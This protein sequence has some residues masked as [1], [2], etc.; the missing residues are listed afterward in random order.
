M[1]GQDGAGENIVSAAANRTAE[2]QSA[3]RASETGGAK[4]LV[5][6]VF[7]GDANYSQYLP[8]AVQSIIEHA[9]K[10][11]HYHIIIFDCGIEADAAQALADQCAAQDNFSCEIKDIAYLLEKYRQRFPER[12]HYTRAMYGRL[13][14]PELCGAYD[15]IIYSDIDVVFERD[16]AELMEIDLSGA[17][18]GAVT[19]LSIEFERAADK[20][21]ARYASE[22]LGLAPD[23]AC[24]YSGL[25]VFNAPLWRA[26]GVTERI[27]RFLAGKRLRC[28][29]QDA[30]TAVC[31]GKITYLAQAWTC[32]ILKDR[33]ERFARHVPPGR[34]PKLDALLA[35]WKAA[36]ISAKTVIHYNGA[37]KPWHTPHVFL[38][39]KWW[40]YARRTAFY[41][42]YNHLLLRD[43]TRQDFPTKIYRFLGVP[44]WVVKTTPFEKKY[45][46]GKYRLAKKIYND[47]GSALYILGIK[48]FSAGAG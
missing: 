16:I 44:V 45:L 27:I 40:H 31:R 7:C 15:R 21:M 25:L 11:C 28:P 4:K 14:I 24:I 46:L 39:E 36:C 9:A 48:L 2:Q 30:I 8:V 43:M 37:V 42:Y 1:A 29:D 22:I 33:I 20:K 26:D 32:V 41:P 6:I 18:I 12:L 13:F 17:Y 5:P 19:E 23:M 47:K 35:E 3:A 34:C 10:S 38:G